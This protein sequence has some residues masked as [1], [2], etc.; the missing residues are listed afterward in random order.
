MTTTEKT[1]ITIEA[2]VKALPEAVWALWTTPE[3]ITGWNHASPDWHTPEAENDLKEGGR[4]RFRMESRDGT[5]G[6]D[7]TGSYD[8]VVPHRVIRYTMDD[9]RKASI[10]FTPQG[11]QTH[12][13]QTFEAETTHDTEMQRAGWQAILD[14]FK[15]YAEAANEP[16]RLHF[17]ATIDAPADKVYQNMLEDKSYRQWTS[18]F[19]PTS[20][21]EGS[22]EK[23]S[24]ILFIGLDAEG[25]KG[26]MVSRIRENIPG[27]FVSI[28]HIGLLNKGEEITSGPEVEAW[29]GAQENYSFKQEGDKTLVSVE[30]D[31]IKSFE[32]FFHDTWPKALAELKRLCE[33]E[34]VLH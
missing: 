14:N 9:G 8:E 33:A 19:C 28:E 7:F 4:F 24:K 5:M 20:Y 22:W 12:I 2:T 15:R 13:S 10:T 31:S 16:V 18:V 30:L 11:N 3:H 26:G 23:G 1:N 25:N 27:K 17:T 6:F 29:A 21:F 34:P 32:A